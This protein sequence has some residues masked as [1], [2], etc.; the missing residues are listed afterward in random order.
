MELMGGLEEMEDLE[1]WENRYNIELVHGQILIEMVTSMR[2][3]ADML[4]TK[5][6]M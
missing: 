4:L 6:I 5:I 1:G 3:H 2:G